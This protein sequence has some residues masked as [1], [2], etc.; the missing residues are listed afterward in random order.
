[1]ASRSF[2]RNWIRNRYLIVLRPRRSDSSLLRY[3]RLQFCLL[4]ARGGRNDGFWPNALLRVGLALGDASR[5][6]LGIKERNQ[7]LP[8]HRHDSWKHGPDLVLI[9]DDYHRDGLLIG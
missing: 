8:H 5:D 2:G 1:M 4:R 3:G 6:H 7:T 9:V